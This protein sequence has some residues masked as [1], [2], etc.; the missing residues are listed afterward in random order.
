MK[1]L[2]LNETKTLVIENLKRV[3]SKT[4]GMFSRAHNR[5][6]SHWLYARVT[7]WL[8]QRC[9][10][11]G[12]RL[13]KVLPYK[14]SQFCRFCGNW[15][16]RNRKGDK[17]SCVHCGHTDRADSNAA[18]NLKLLGLAGVYSLRLL[19]TSEDICL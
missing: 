12:V 17:F 9:E 15:D 14:T 16:R 7:K 3:K 8:E 18:E 13:V 4:R 11:Q 1:K 19:K 5:R 6:L 2:E 10:E